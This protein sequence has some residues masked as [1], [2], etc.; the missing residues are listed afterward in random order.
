MAM[1]ATVTKSSINVNALEVPS[2]SE[3]F[4]PL[5]FSG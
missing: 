1:M 4:S 2:L 5:S 3:P